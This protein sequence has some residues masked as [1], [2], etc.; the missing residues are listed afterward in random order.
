VNRAEPRTAASG[1]LAYLWLALVCLAAVWTFRAALG[2]DFI[3]IDDKGNIALNAHMG[4]PGPWNLHWM[5]TDADYV[6]R[7]IPLGWLGFSAVFAVSGLSPLGYHAANLALHAANTALLF[8]VLVMALRRWNPRAGDAW[9][10]PCAAL[11]CALWAL[12]PFRAE[13]IG[14]VSGM[15]YGQAGLFALASVVAYLRATALPAG[16]PARRAWLVASALAFLASLLTYPL[17]VGLVAVFFLIDLADGRPFRIVRE[18]GLFVLAAAGVAAVTVGVRYRTN[19]MWP[20]APSLADFPIAARLMQAFYVAAYYVWKTLAPT[21]LTPAPTQLY[22]FDP[23]GPVFIA[24]ALGVA[25]LTAAL[26]LRPGWRRGPLLLWLAYI[27]LVLPVAGLTEHPHYPNDRYS[28]LTGMVLALAAALGLGRIPRGPMRAAAALAAVLAAL[29]SASSARAQLEKWR[30]SD[31]VFLSIINGTWNAAVRRDNFS[32][33]AKASADLGRFETTRTIL[34]EWGR[35]Y[36]GTAPAFSPPAEGEPFYEAAAHLKI[37]IEA[38]RAERTV[39]AEAHFRRSLAIEPSYE[40]AQYNFAM[41]L[42]LH[43]SPREALHLYFILSGG[44]GRL[45]PEAECALLSVIARA[46]WDRGEEAQA[47]DAVDLALARA[48]QGAAYDSL[49]RQARDYGAQTLP[50]LRDSTIR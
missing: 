21:R 4:P 39:E 18:K 27:A 24:A 15:L 44:G 16:Q 48:G 20:A 50:A 25:A 35:E 46:F 41:F 7:Y 12:H 43:G 40:D 17:A 49:R 28:Y 30:N 14:W 5:F 9:N 33:W 19:A 26:W 10:L 2:F 22:A 11:A 1:R 45:G 3:A 42:G 13:S 37:A 36:P 31:S 38:A 8:A 29:A 6:R 34:A 47:R 32:K 23:L